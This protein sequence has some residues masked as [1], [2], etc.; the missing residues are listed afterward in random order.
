MKPSRAGFDAISAVGAGGFSV[1]LQ[2][3]YFVAGFL[4]FD[5]GNNASISTSWVKVQGGTESRARSPKK[6]ASPLT[7]HEI[8]PQ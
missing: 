5:V 6:S 2:C 8:A 1:M 7:L 4:G 3:V